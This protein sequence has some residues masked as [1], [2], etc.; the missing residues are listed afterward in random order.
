MSDHLRCLGLGN[1]KVCLTETV[2]KED[3]VWVH[4]TQERDQ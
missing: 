4:L 3:V 2:C 1:I